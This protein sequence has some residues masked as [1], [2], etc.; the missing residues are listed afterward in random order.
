MYTKVINF[1]PK[2]NTMDMTKV[3][4]VIDMQN[5]FVTGTLA[6]EEAQKIV[7]AIETKIQ[8]CQND[9]HPVFFTR[10]THGDDYMQTQEGA[11]LPVIHCLKGSEGWQIIDQLK[12]YVEKD[13]V[14]DK[15]S[16]GC[17]EL[18]RWLERKLGEKPKEV[19][20]CGVCTDIC[21]I[22][23]AI[24]LKAAFPETKVTVSG[25]C[26]AGVTPQSHR[27]A[28]EAMKACQIIVE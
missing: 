1:V 14:L 2:E 16:F 8:S 27:N 26:C 15:P 6:N 9:A 23:N 17:L 24:I 11:L 5:D 18:P 25:D 10:D 20:L 3:L 21:V 28:L 4:I 13:A 12:P 19:E 7:A 22:S